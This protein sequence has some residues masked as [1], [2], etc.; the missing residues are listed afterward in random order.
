MSTRRNENERAARRDTEASAL[1]VVYNLS[2]LRNT[3][4]TAIKQLLAQVDRCL[5]SHHDACAAPYS[6][7]SHAMDAPVSPGAHRAAP[8]RASLTVHATT[9]D[10]TC[11]QITR[12]PLIPPPWL[13]ISSC[14]TAALCSASELFG[15]K[16][17]MFVNFTSCTPP[18]SLRCC[19]GTTAA[20]QHTCQ[21]SRVT[22]GAVGSQ[23][24][25]AL[26]SAT[27]PSHCRDLNEHHHTH[28]SR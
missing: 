4:T 16:S 2:L 3:T 7:P 20:F 13:T 1:H 18:H 19:C 11:R 25:H 24:C 17:D 28:P 21:H 9:S 10:G 23:R 6:L 14:L 12:H 5:V 22:I 26:R 8:S 27:S 15:F